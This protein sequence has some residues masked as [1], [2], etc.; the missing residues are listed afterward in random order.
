MRVYDE[1]ARRAPRVVMRVVSGT[2]A[3]EE[4]TREEVLEQAERG[5]RALAS[6]GVRRGD[7]VAVQMERGKAQTSAF[8]AVWRLGAC[9]VPLFERLGSEGVG[10]RLEQSGAVLQLGGMA[11]W[12]A[13]TR[14]DRPSVAEQPVSAE[15]PLALLFT[16]G[17]SGRPKGVA[18]TSRS[19]P[20]AEAYLRT[21]LAL[22]P[23]GGGRFF[24]AADPAWAYG[25][26]YNLLGPLWC[27]LSVHHLAPGAPLSALAALAP[28]DLAAA[29]AFYGLLSREQVPLPGLQR[30]SSAGELMGQAL[31]DQWKVG[32]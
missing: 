7:R 19:L 5:S 15:E 20:S 9:V 6:R 31:R 21:G 1:M 12:E 3:V 18:V 10:T 28:T 4:V 13:M 24:N 22:E 29:P 30:C 14:E 32:S 11:Q 23:G 17:T 27:G 8:L 25:L 26:Y 2:G 16:S